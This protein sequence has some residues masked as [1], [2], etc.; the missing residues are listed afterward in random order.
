MFHVQIDAL[1]VV[2]NTQPSFQVSR[3]FFREPKY[4]N[5]GIF[6]FPDGP[7]NKAMIQKQLC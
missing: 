1:T 6:H 4:D 5:A 7:I 2:C 3:Q